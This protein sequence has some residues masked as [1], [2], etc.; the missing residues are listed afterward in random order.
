MWMNNY[1]IKVL[2]MKIISCDSVLYIS[3]GQ[4]SLWIRETSRSSHL[5]TLLHWYN[6]TH[7]SN[8]DSIQ[9]PDSLKWTVWISRLCSVIPAMR[10]LIM[11]VIICLQTCKSAGKPAHI[12]SLLCPSSYASLK[13]NNNKPECKGPCTN[14]NSSLS[15]MPTKWWY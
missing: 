14:I 9:P 7:W 10:K 3:K 4:S 11:M 8:A 6:I 1:C 12:H 13:N 2:G 5:H 15:F